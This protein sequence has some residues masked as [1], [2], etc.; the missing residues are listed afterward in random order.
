MKFL[1]INFSLTAFRFHNCNI[2]IS[3]NTLS[4]MQETLSQLFE[5]IQE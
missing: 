5:M 3:E 2:V 1:V 4:Q